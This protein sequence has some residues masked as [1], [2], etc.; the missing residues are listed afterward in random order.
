MQKR[1]KSKWTN[2]AQDDGNVRDREVE[3]PICK[4][5]RIP[6]AVKEEEGGGGEREAQKI[7]VLH[8]TELHRSI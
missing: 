7:T 8:C 6:R 3:E 1:V 4:L 2:I 5:W